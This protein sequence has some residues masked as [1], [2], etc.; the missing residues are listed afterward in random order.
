MY[1]IKPYTSVTQNNVVYTV[2]ILFI[3]YFGKFCIFIVSPV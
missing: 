3:Y 2:L 1:T